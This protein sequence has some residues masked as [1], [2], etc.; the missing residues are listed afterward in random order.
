MRKRKAT[1]AGDKLI[2]TQA[3]PGIPSCDEPYG[4][5]IAGVG[6]T[7]IVTLGALLGM[8]ARLE[9]KGVT[10]LDKAG[11]AQ[12]Y[13]AVVTHVRVAKAPEGLRDPSRGQGVPEAPLHQ[14]QQAGQGQPSSDP[15]ARA[16]HE[17][18]LLQPAVLRIVH[19]VVT[20]VELCPRQM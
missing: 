11:L 17:A 9:G 2:A 15:V 7:G 13:G 12:K 1:G 19:P 20:V 4:I 6:G 16:E 3:E 18:L 14:G 8:A 5:V 10:V